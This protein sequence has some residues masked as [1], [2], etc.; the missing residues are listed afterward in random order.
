M[1]LALIVGAI[2][3]L[4]L[5]GCS[6]PSVA[7]Q[8]SSQRPSVAPPPPL[9]P[10]PQAPNGSPTREAERLP[11]ASQPSPE[12]TSKP[13]IITSEAA[14]HGHSDAHATRDRQCGR[15]MRTKGPW[16][17]LVAVSAPPGDA[18]KAMQQRVLDTLPT[19]AVLY[20]RLTYG[21]L[22][23]TIAKAALDVLCESPFVVRI[24]RTPMGTTA[25]GTLH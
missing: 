10:L 22:N 7:P 1:K 3:A 16:D 21:Y 23:V 8:Q 24:E 11:A 15:L 18:A 9:P 14:A 12:P 4:A 19:K 20:H 13:T 25:V 5:V 6:G 17:L 2:S